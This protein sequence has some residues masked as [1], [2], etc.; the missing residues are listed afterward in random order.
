MA[1]ASVPFGRFEAAPKQSKIW[2]LNAIITKPSKPHQDVTDKVLD[3]WA[4][5]WNVKPIS[6]T[7]ILLDCRQVLAHQAQQEKAMAAWPLVN[8]KW[9]GVKA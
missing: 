7:Q 5:W 8:L 1:V 2:L 9:C 4:T 3:T 6:P